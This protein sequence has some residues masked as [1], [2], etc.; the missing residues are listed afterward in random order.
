MFTDNE[1][2]TYNQKMQKPR[3]GRPKI[4]SPSKQELKN[5][6]KVLLQ[7]IRRQNQKL[8]NMSRLFTLTTKKLQQRNLLEKDTINFL[9]EEFEG[10]R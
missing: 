2:I 4:K 5:K 7:K 9:M 8:N 1:Q 3:R 10:C 6:I